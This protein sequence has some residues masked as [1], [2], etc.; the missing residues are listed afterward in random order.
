MAQQLG[1]GFDEML[2]EQRPAHLPATI[3]FY[4]GLIESNMPR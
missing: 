4:R 1:F 2:E 3:P